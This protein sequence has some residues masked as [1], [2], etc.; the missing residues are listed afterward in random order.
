MKENKLRAKQNCGPAYYVTASL[1]ILLIAVSI[2]IYWTVPFSDIANSV[3]YSAKTGLMLFAVS[4]VCALV[5]TIAYLVGGLTDKALVRNSVVQ[6]VIFIVSA[7]LSAFISFVAVRFMIAQL[8]VGFVS[9]FDTAMVWGKLG[10]AMIVS[11][12]L[13]A[14]GNIYIFVTARK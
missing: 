12:V 4:P 9:P 14:A 2:I 5:A 7:V 8:S 3:E 10:I 1:S 11:G 6:L 13:L